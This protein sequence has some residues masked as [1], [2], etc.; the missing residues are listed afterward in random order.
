MPSLNQFESQTS[1]CMPILTFVYAVREIVVTSL[2]SLRLTQKSYLDV[3]LELFLR[4]VQFH[5]GQLKSVGE[6]EAKKFCF[7]MTL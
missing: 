1:E 6:N 7:A 3:Q 5:L 2:V 4:H